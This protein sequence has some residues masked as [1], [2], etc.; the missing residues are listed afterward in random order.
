MG[1]RSNSN[2]GKV[3]KFVHREDEYFLTNI[4]GIEYHHKDGWF[5]I[6]PDGKFEIRASL[7]KGYAWDGCTP[8]WELL[9]LIVGTPDGRLDYLTEEPITY[10]ASMVHDI[11]YQFKDEI[12]VSRNTADKLFHI[13]MKQADYWWRGLYFAIVSLF[14]GIYGGWKSNEKI[15]NIEIRECSWIIKAYAKCQDL[16][17]VNELKDHPFIKTARTYR[18]LDAEVRK[19]DLK[20]Y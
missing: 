12:P 15:Q 9:D 2:T 17:K 14:G 4:T 1:K 18:D 11:L 3:Y 16:E 7:G 20:D 5:S 13:I 8:K 6:H 10:Y 19:L